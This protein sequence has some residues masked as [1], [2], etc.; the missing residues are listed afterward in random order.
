MPHFYKLN[1]TNT[2]IASLTTQPE[3]VLKTPILSAPPVASC[4]S[5]QLDEQVKRHPGEA[6][7]DY[8]Q[9]MKRML[10]KA[11]HPDPATPLLQRASTAQKIRNQISNLLGQ[12]RDGCQNPS[13]K[14][15]EEF[16][17]Y[18]NQ[19]VLA[20]FKEDQKPGPRPPRYNPDGV[21]Q[22][23]RKPVIQ[24]AV[25]IGSGYDRHQAPFVNHEN[26]W[27]K[28]LKSSIIVDVYNVMKADRE[29]FAT[30]LKELTYRV[31][32]L[33]Y[34]LK[35]VDDTVQ[36][37]YTDWLKDS[38]Y[39]RE[40]IA[41]EVERVGWDTDRL[42]RQIDRNH[43]F[44]MGKEMRGGINHFHMYPLPK[45]AYYDEPE[46][47]QPD[48]NDSGIQLDEDSDSCRGSG[49]SE[50]SEVEEVCGSD[51][52]PLTKS[53]VELC[54]AVCD[55]NGADE[56]LPESLESSVS[57]DDSF[58][59]IVDEEKVGIVDLPDCAVNDEEIGDDDVFWPAEEL[60]AAFGEQEASSGIRMDNDTGDDALAD[61]SADS[62]QSVAE[63]T[64]RMRKGI[65]GFFPWMVVLVLILLLLVKVVRFGDAV[66]AS[67]ADFVNGDG[68]NSFWSTY[69]H[70]V[71]TTEARDCFAF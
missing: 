24:N 39:I 50:C 44:V 11:V 64:V 68:E 61:E 65:R 16:C 43:D 20:I 62:A 3:N 71:K 46:E 30:S 67:I 41:W 52:I 26:N 66:A 70:C 22:S 23:V 28:E 25:A 63:H 51:H 9:R 15:V 7:A 32:E 35:H 2:S 10:E 55:S 47:M 27:L 60:V 69:L 40:R 13:K 29:Y 38:Q 58:Q 18:A 1:V 42:Q 33:T 12:M 6:T 45:K 17:V 59:E 34:K 14:E 53:D 37:T 19:K 21:P 49:T 54:N 57:L 36:T 31:D 4:D 48:T 8:Y 56:Y 5:D